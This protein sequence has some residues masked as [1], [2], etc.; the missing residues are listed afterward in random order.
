MRWYSLA[1]VVAALLVSSVAQ[2]QWSV[3]GNKIY[4]A[5]GKVG[6]GTAN[7]NSQLQVVSYIG[8]SDRPCLLV[9]NLNTDPEVDNAVIKGLH[10]SATANG[11]GVWGEHDGSGWGVYGVAHGG[12]S[13]SIGVYGR[14]FGQGIAVRG[15]AAVN[16]YAGYFNGRCYIN[17]QLGIGVPL[18]DYDLHLQADSA[19]K[20]TSSTWTI[21]SDRRLKKNIKPIIGALGR[22]MALQGVTYQ[23]KYPES[24]GNMT[25][26]Y[27]GMIAQDVEPVFPEWI[28]ERENGYKTLTVIGFEGIVVEALRELR[29]E[30]D[31]EIEMLRCEKD[32]EIA[33]RDQ[34]I[35]SLSAR[36]A[37]LERA[38]L[39][40]NQSRN[41]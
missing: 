13:T 6:I 16:G 26:T 36:L 15:T 41:D 5:S 34:Q 39:E 29:A 28:R 21:D 18:P 11:I 24:Q 4:Y 2:A 31:A 3:N 9:K 20:P 19:A 35:D 14:A 12:A 37:H 10:R 7:P 32:E 1:A 22:L 17:G 25:G 27:T 23:W 38:V 40:M 30:N 8:L 33:L